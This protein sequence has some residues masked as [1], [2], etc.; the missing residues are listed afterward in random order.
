MFDSSHYFSETLG[1]SSGLLKP[2]TLPL[3]HRAPVTCLTPPHIRVFTFQNILKSI[4][5]FIFNET[6]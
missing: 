5:V 1:P 3:D 6:A 2:G 4:I